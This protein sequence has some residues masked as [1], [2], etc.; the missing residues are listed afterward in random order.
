MTK[1]LSMLSVPT[2]F[3]AGLLVS[4]MVLGGRAETPSEDSGARSRP[5]IEQPIRQ[6]EGVLASLEQQQPRNYTITNI[7]FLYDALLYIELNERERLLS[8]SALEEE[9]ER[10]RRWA[11]RRA[12]VVQ[13]A[14]KEYEG[15]SLAPFVAAEAAIKLTKERL[16]ELR[17]TPTSR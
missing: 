7:S 10:Q 4:W 2:V 5:N 3:V 6:L 1:R 17:K 15:G 11:A 8:G 12:E 14:A 16:A 13:A 9:R